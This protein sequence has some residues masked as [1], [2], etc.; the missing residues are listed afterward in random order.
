M[1]VLPLH[2]PPP[3]PNTVTNAHHTIM[4]AH[5]CTALQIQLRQ[6]EDDVEFRVIARGQEADH[7]GDWAA[8]QGVLL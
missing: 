2:V 6:L 4:D 7:D 3:L 8:L 5:H 1:K